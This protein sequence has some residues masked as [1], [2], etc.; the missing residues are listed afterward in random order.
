[1]YGSKA[2]RKKGVGMPKPRPT[3][4]AGD[5]GE[6]LPYPKPMRNGGKVH[7]DEAQDRVLINSIV[8]KKLKARGLKKGGKVKC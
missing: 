5:F 6:R 8:D 4:T 7:D 3:T 1:M 2:K